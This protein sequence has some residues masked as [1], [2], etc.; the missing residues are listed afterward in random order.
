MD[1]R[2]GTQMTA[3]TKAQS[4]S[5]GAKKLN[6]NFVLAYRLCSPCMY[7]S[8]KGKEGAAWSC[9]YRNIQMLCSALLL[10]RSSAVVSTDVAARKLQEND[11]FANPKTQAGTLQLSKQYAAALFQGNGEIPD[12]NGIQAWIEKAW[13]AGF[14]V[15]VVKES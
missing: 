13:A 4:M 7:V 11:D 2:H 14:D 6:N 15:E 8:Q 10:L 3:P 9:G 1:A 12:V 5:S